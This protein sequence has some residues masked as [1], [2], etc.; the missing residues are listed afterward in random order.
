M[1]FRPRERLRSIRRIGL[2]GR[3]RS[4]QNLLEKNRRG[5]DDSRPLFLFVLG[6][7]LKATQDAMMVR[8]WGAA[9]VRPSD[10]E[11]RRS[12]GTTLCVRVMQSYLFLE[13]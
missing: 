8:I 9:V 1:R 13:S 6:R 5:R 7:A 11:I 2:A 3:R 10:T 12:N 4:Q